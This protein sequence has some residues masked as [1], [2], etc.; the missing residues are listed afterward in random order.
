MGGVLLGRLDHGD[1]GD[2]GMTIGSR[3][4]DERPDHGLGYGQS[5]WPMAEDMVWV[6]GVWMTR[7]DAED[8]GF[9]K[10]GKDK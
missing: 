8:K 4:P 10:L 5:I 9:F 1:H 3:K 6:N 7:K 2:H